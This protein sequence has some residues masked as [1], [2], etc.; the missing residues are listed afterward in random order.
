MRASYF[1]ALLILVAIGGWLYSGELIVSGQGGGEPAVAEEET[2]QS[3]PEPAEAAADEDAPFAVKVRR[4][5][6]EERQQTLTLRGHTEAKQKVTLRAQTSGLVEEIPVAKG[7]QVEEGDLVCRIEDGNRQAQILRAEAALA[8]AQQEFDA[9]SSLNKQGYAAETRLRQ[10]KAALDAAK[11]TLSEARLDLERTEIR[12]PFRGVVHALP[13][14]T[15][16]LLNIGEPCAE[17]MSFDPML[18][19]ADVSERNI[20][21]LE[22]GMAGTVDLVTGQSAEGEL[23]F[24]APSASTATRTFRIE[25]RLANP[26]GALRDGTTAKITIPL[27]TTRAHFF[28]PAVLTLNEE[29]QV[30]VRVVEDG[31][32]VAFMPVEIV[33]DSPDGVWVEG[34]SEEVTLITV[35]QEYVQAGETVTPVFET[36]EADR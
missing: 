8:Q 5:T 11:A 34:L 22:R 15:G 28:S 13:A 1:W 9:S 2:G 33:Q 4:S 29:G 6:A 36:A 21:A 26:D 25:M 17:V 23:S 18:A 14:E 27:E 12:A 30:G 19:V 32:T 31:D 20:E 7:D 10:S 35:G 16:A 3:A 24:I